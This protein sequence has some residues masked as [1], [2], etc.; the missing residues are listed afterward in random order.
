[1]NKYTHA[2]PRLSLCVMLLSLLLAA[3]VGVSFALVKIDWEVLNLF[4]IV[5]LGAFATLALVQW[6]W[7]IYTILES[8]KKVWIHSCI[9]KDKE[10]SYERSSSR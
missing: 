4:E 1:M 2:D 8:M 5:S 9:K 7:E 3:G 6:G 10:P